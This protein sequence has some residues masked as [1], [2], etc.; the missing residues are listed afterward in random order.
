MNQEEKEILLHMSLFK[1]PSVLQRLLNARR[2]CTR[3]DYARGF[4][5][6][7]PGISQ[8]D[9]I[10][11]PSVSGYVKETCLYS[12]VKASRFVEEHR[13]AERLWSYIKTNMSSLVIN[14]QDTE[15]V[16]KLGPYV[17][18][19]MLV[20]D[21]ETE[22]FHCPIVCISFINLDRERLRD[23]ETI[24]LES[25]IAEDYL[26]ER[27]LLIKFAKILSRAGKNYTHN[28]SSY[29]GPL[30]DKRLIHQ[31]L[32]PVMYDK[33]RTFKQTR[34][35]HVDLRHIL[36]LFST[37]QLPDESLKTREIHLFDLRRDGDIDGSDIAQA[38]FQHSYRSQRVEVVEVASRTIWNNAKKQAADTYDPDEYPDLFNLAAR[39]LY[40]Q[41]MGSKNRPPYKTEFKP[42]DALSEDDTAS[43]MKRIVEHNMLDVLS[44]L[45]E[46]VFLGANFRNKK[47]H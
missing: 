46:L 44:T 25:L 23:P 38:F 41:M 32:Y 24:S 15:K 34:D 33:K 27:P 14:G 37:C 39:Q 3:V 12:G 4:R 2:V 8:E 7:S 42:G 40:E 16:A 17:S 28:G 21:T 11:K 36:R 26:Q 19:N 9:F 18:D 45:G 13:E 20:W 47:N 29:D 35:R 22:G 10:E 43:Q 31:L 30:F 5:G 6:V 1:M